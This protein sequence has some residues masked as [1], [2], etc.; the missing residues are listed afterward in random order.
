VITSAAVGAE[1]P[2]RHE[3]DAAYD[4]VVIGAGQAGLAAGHQLASR[5]LRFLILD[6]NERIGDQW[7]ARWDS[8][9]LFTP[10]R[11]DGLPGLPFPA[12]AHVFPTKDEMADYLASYAA[13]FA[14]PVRLGT[15][16]DRLA[17]HDG[18]FVVEAGAERFLADAVVLAMA[19]YQRPRTPAFAAELR[20]DIVQLH[21]FEYRGPAQLRPGGVLVV[22][23][24]NSGAEIATES[25]RSRPT[26]LAGRHPGHLPFRI[27]GSWGRHLLMPLLLRFLFRHVLSV[28]TPIGRRVRPKVLRR[29]GPLIRVKPRDMAAAGIVTV[30]RVAG[31]RDGLPL[32]EDGRL[33]DVENV[34]W[35]TGYHADEDWVDL[36]EWRAGDRDPPR[37]IVPA[38]PGLYRLGRHFQTSLSSAMIHGVGRDAAYVAAAIA[39]R[40]RRRA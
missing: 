8:L 13:H 25:V 11:F 23:A 27:E 35:C 30:P 37:G 19:N 40:A 7:R 34:I 28:G 3:P 15:R 14:L 10:A 16:V 6:A 1:A 17:R 26:W 22:G 33:L 31:V 39:A 29:A 20:P 32:L 12:P 38:E 4:V 5:G 24:G 9:R 21:S 2:H 18:R 36:P